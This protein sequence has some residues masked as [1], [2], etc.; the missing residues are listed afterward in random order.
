[1]MSNEDFLIDIH[2]IEFILYIEKGY[3]LLYVLVFDILKDE[4]F[5]RRMSYGW[6]FE[7]A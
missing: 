5:E 2:K 1:M 3:C 4:F 7:M 6:S